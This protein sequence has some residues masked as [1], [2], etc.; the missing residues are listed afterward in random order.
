MKDME[1]LDRL[2]SQHWDEAIHI[3]IGHQDS[4]LQCRCR[5]PNRS[6]GEIESISNSGT[7]AF[8]SKPIRKFYILMEKTKL[9]FGPVVL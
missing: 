9:V 6:L 4:V 8:V 7:I 2:L 5:R 3:G 1:N